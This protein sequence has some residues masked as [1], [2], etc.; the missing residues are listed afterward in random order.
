MKKKIITLLLAGSLVLSNSAIAFAA[1][2]SE[3]DQSDVVAEEVVTTEEGTDEAATE[4]T[5]E[6]ETTEEALVVEE[7]KPEVKETAETTEYQYVSPAE[8]VAAENGVIID[9]RVKADYDAAHIRGSVHSPVFATI[10]GTN[11]PAG[12]YDGFVKD[13]TA[14]KAE[15]EG[16]NIL[17]LCY[18]GNRGAQ[19]A[20][21]ALKE[22]GY[23]MSKVFTIEGGA[24]ASGEL[25]D[26]YV[27][28]Q[29]A[30][31]AYWSNSA[32]IIDLRA[33][34]DYVAG[35]LAR[36]VYLPVFATG[37]ALTGAEADA[38]AETFKANITKYTDKPIYV[39]CYSGNAG[40][41]KAVDLAVE[42]GL[43]RESVKII[44]DGIG[45]KNPAAPLATAS[46]TIYVPG[47]QAV[48]AL[49]TNE[50]TVLDLRPYEEYEKAHLKGATWLP[51]F[52]L[53][54]ESLVAKMQAK[55]PELIKAGKPV[56]VLCYTGNKG[57][58]KATK[59]L[60]D[61]G[62][63]YVYTVR[64][65]AADANVKEA[66]RYV[67]DTVAVNPGKDGVVIDV[68][69]T[70]EQEKTG[71]LPGS[72]SLPIVEG[73][74]KNMTPAL[75]A[76]FK[77]YVE[78][79]KAELAGKKIYLLCYSGNNCAKRATELLAELGMTENVYTVEGG[80]LS[81]LIQSKFVKASDETAKPNDDK[82]EENK[83]PSKNPQTGDPAMT[84]Q[85][86]VAMGAAALALV[87]RKKFL[88]R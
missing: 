1:P 26:Y 8:A 9:L 13:M 19:N 70:V 11:D 78:E 31:D 32:Y 42:A 46:K 77:K 52:P 44:T 84:L 71:V 16:K 40:A 12:N 57:A 76:A 88:N 67:S 41:Q 6:T 66:S 86:T 79:H 72:I 47:A 35:H 62:V 74:D 53:D 5:E 45:E 68:R 58:Y 63:K 49:A 50:A 3:A 14:K 34:S 64:G 17:L 10:N 65:G 24:K 51:I 2:E 38:L 87:K 30:L 69:A 55:A 59:A 85:Y 20:T 60:L 81:T 7:E 28:N 83:K 33:E 82:K 25:L 22:C 4:E 36:F 15:Y 48:A 56:Y 18:S 23:D 29:E 75:D 43:K 54:D 21:A 73:E 37:K 80:A 39:L 61:A 27:S